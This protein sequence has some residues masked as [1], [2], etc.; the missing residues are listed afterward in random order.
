M[1][2]VIQTQFSKR[3]P[4]CVFQGRRLAFF[5]VVFNVAY[6]GFDLRLEY[7]REELASSGALTDTSNLHGTHQLRGDVGID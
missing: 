2:S 7:L 4:P 1:F 5:H 6:M 3:A